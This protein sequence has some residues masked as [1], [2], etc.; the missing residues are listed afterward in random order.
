[1]TRKA[2]VTI[3]REIVED[4]SPDVS[5]LDQEDWQER[6]AQYARGD[7]Y[8]VGV[9][10]VALISVPYGQDWIVTQLKSPGLWCIESD[11]GDDYLTEVFEEEKK[12]LLDMLASLRDY[13][14][15]GI[16]RE[17]CPA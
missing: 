5:Y 4:D 2:E 6:R 7:F 14:L 16:T 11:S 9:R 17:S 12:T 8:F 3:H 10:A 1:M 15:S 13:E